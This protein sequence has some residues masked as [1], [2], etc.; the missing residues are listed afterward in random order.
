MKRLRCVNL[1]VVLTL[2]V[3][4]LAWLPAPVQA[5]PAAFDC[6]DRDRHA[7]KLNARRWW[8]CTNPRMGITGTTTPTG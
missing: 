7:L 6:G 3:G 5:A 2:L 1:V 4:W 8:R